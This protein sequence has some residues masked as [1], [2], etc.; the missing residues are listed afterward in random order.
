M[1]QQFPNPL[2]VMALEMEG[3]AALER[4][5][6]PVL[7]T[8]VGKVNASYSLARRLGEY[9]C[10]DEPLPLVVNFGTAGSRSFRTGDVVACGTFVQ[11]DMDVTALKCDIGVTPFDT[12]PSRIQFPPML[13]DLPQGV[14]GT[15]DSF[16]V[17]HADVA[18]NVLDMEAFALA[19]VCWFYGAQFISV[20]Y[21]TDNAD[22]GAAGDWQQNLGKAAEEF[23]LVYKRLSEV[24]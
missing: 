3:G 1:R 6:I 23:L 21:I 19:K 12:A 24:R 9:V 5:G 11:R 22:T 7:F 4:G 14:C 16:A 10:A 17:L 20:K 2:V 8:G 18:C 13:E 15:G